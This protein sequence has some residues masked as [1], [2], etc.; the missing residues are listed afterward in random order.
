MAVRRGQGQRTLDEY[1]ELFRP[2]QDRRR[3]GE[4]SVWYLYSP[5]ASREIVTAYPTAEIIVMVRNPID[6]LA[7]LHSEFVQ[8]EIEPVD[9]F[10]TALG[11]DE[12]R[13]REGAPPGFPPDSYRAAVRYAEQIER[14]LD[15]FGRDRVHVILYEDLR[16][17]ALAV[18]RSTCVFI[19]VDPGFHPDLRIINPNRRTRSRWI[20]RLITR[21]PEPV[22]AVLHRVSSQRLR[23]ATAIRLMKMNRRVA[24][25]EAVDDRVA[26]ALRSD[27][28]REVA[29]LDALLGLDATRWLRANAAGQGSTSI[30]TSSES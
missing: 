26:E 7:S 16:D 28:A 2:L 30:E 20:Q 8:R 14:Y 19:G 23:R 24:P 17:D 25:R 11:L 5:D 4:A 21:P 9:D 13:E 22:R 3:L 1:L 12:V 29:A 15:V 6:M 10:T 27:V 18:F